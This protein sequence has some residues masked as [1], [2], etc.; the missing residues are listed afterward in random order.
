LE[1]KKGKPHGAYREYFEDG[2]IRDS[3][4]YKAG[5]ISGDFWPSGQLKRKESKQ[6]KNRIIEWF[7]PNG[8]IQKRYVKDK[9][10]Y[11][12]EPIRL[13]HENGMLAE[14][15]TAVK[16][17]KRGPWLKF[18]DDGTPELQAEYA[19][20]EKLIVHNAWNEKREQVVK[21]GAGTFRDYPVRIDWEYEVFFENGWPRVSELKGGIPHGKVTTYNRDVLWSIDQYVEGKPDGES[22]TYWDNGRIR[23]VTKFENE[24]EE[25]SKNFPKY[26][27]PIPVVL[28]NVEANEKLYAAWR[29]IGV[30]EYPQALNLVDVRKQLKVPQFLREV[31]ERNLAGK[32]KDDYEACN[33]FNDGIAYLLTVD[34]FGDVT[35]A[36]ANGS[37]V[38][39]GGD[40]DTYPPLLRKLRFAPGRIRGRA[41]ECRVLA[42]VHHTFID[43]EK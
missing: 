30:D 4:F 14:E 11:A 35:A 3:V 42:T 12:V 6:G 23:S 37:G 34:E 28:L 25:K 21:D 2:S 22:T 36:T 5:K 24:M 32:L 38:Y 26:D 20:D 41:I 8:S 1:V 10:G 19:A 39:S 18:F 29:H 15:L 27:D 33:T 7:Y 13:F 40:W 9:D 17:K 16:G 31:H 43:R